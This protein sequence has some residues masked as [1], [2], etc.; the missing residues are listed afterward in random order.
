MSTIVGT[1][2]IAQGGAQLGRGNALLGAAKRA[3]VATMTWRIE[4][5]AIEQRSAMSEWQ[6]KDIGLTRS[7]IAAAAIES[8]KSPRVWAPVAGAAMFQING[9][10]RKVS[11]WARDNTPVFGS[12]RSAA[13]WSDH[14][15]TA[16]SVAYLATV[17]AIR[18]QRG[19]RHD[20]ET[21]Q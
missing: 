4:R 6:L 2:A 11:N 14:L 8:A 15:R 1:A 20:D 7:E 18:V 21:C 12:Q 9:W 16:S 5:V 3:W 19:S 10:D 17:L 13:D